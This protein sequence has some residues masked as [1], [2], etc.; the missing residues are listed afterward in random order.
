MAD[1]Q[2]A[3]T[4]DT[5]IQQQDEAGGG[6]AVPMSTAQSHGQPPAAAATTEGGGEAAQ[7][8]QNKDGKEDGPAQPRQ[9]MES[10]GKEGAGVSSMEEASH[11]QAEPVVG[12]GKQGED[13]AAARSGSPSQEV[14]AAV[15]AA[16]AAGG[17]SAGPG[18]QGS[19]G[20][21]KAARHEGR[22]GPG[23]G[24]PGSATNG[25]SGGGSHFSGG[26]EHLMSL[27]QQHPDQEAAVTAALSAVQV[28]TAWAISLEHACAC[29][30]RFCACLRV[31]CSVSSWMSLI[32]MCATCWCSK[33]AGYVLEIIVSA[34]DF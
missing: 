21:V 22:A 32:A 3:P 16:A 10:G 2:E 27:L 34:C 29:L 9:D 28:R 8:A 11:D 18:A 25:S 13:H 30:N 7:D 31:Q 12:E 14:A 24:G 23:G 1:L 26:V 20:P 19:E 6:G 5:V 15:A 33:S 17:G 4:T